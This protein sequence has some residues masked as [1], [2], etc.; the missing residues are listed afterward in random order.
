MNKFPHFSK[1]QISLQICFCLFACNQAAHSADAYSRQGDGQ[2]PK[3]SYLQ[4]GIKEEASL[5]P[6]LKLI[7]SRE[8]Q[9]QS[10]KGQ[11]AWPPG[12]TIPQSDITL[13]QF[14][15]SAR[16]VDGKKESI[17]SQSAQS[18]YVRGISGTIPPISSYSLNQQS[19]LFNYK[20]IYS[21]KPPTSYKGV[22]NFITDFEA[23]PQPISHYKGVETWANGYEVTEVSHDSPSVARLS[24]LQTIGTNI[25]VFY[26]DYLV[27]KVEPTAINPTSP[28][29]SLTP[30]SNR[31]TISVSSANHGV[32]AWAPGYEVTVNVPGL[33]RE[34]LGGIWSTTSH[35]QELTAVPGSLPPHKFPLNKMFVQAEPPQVA[36]AQ[37]L[38]ELASKAREVSPSWDAWYKK[39]A[40]VIYSRWQY[41]DIGLGTARVRVTVTRARTIGATVVDFTP[42]TDIERNIQAETLF[43]ETAIKTINNISDFEIPQFPQE[44]DCQKVHFEVEL[45]RSI[46]GPTGVSII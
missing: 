41:A 20:S 19:Q 9:P 16:Y 22:T 26:P 37:L 29:A 30:N 39:M 8:I 43:R 13:T 17:Q 21:S 10:L 23:P 6:A 4:G 15:G 12:S 36:K 33:A 28:L 42:T 34:T 27:A 5:R 44:A 2:T 25:K 46:N 7:Q 3:P 32:V 40:Q 31:A 18:S 24:E 38:P 1:Y 14:Y 45:K 35:K 11:A